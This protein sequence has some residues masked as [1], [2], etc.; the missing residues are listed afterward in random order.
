MPYLL[1]LDS[2]SHPC[3][4][5][6]LIKLTA[7]H[8]EYNPDVIVHVDSGIEFLDSYLINTMLNEGGCRMLDFYFRIVEDK[9]PSDGRYVI[10]LSIIDNEYGT[11]ANVH[12]ILPIA[13]NITSEANTHQQQWLAIVPVT[14]FEPDKKAIE[15][16]V[17]QGRSETEFSQTV[18]T[19]SNTPIST[20]PPAATNTAVPPPASVPAHPS[21]S[22]SMPQSIVDPTVTLTPSPAPAVMS[23]STQYTKNSIVEE[24][25]DC[26]TWQYPVP[27]HGDDISLWNAYQNYAAG[28][29]VMDLNSF[30]AGFRYCNGV[31]ESVI[32]LHADRSYVFPNGSY[33]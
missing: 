13:V 15:Y 32:I 24:K 12:E 4:G 26:S 23:V 27:L 16:L 33:P 5:H 18:S 21:T 6:L 3:S 25:L 22:T 14:P 8:D 17:Q 20:A 2:V 31:T 7:S 30:V 11:A 29:I 1:K 9:R 28:K 19:G 10:S